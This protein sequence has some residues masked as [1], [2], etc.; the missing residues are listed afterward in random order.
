MN[1]IVLFV[2]LSFFSYQEKNLK[3]FFILK[4]IEIFFFNF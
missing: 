2:I 1:V 3:M 4:Y